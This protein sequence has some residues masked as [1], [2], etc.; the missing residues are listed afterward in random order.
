MLKYNTNKTTFGTG[1]LGITL[2]INYNNIPEIL[3]IFSLL[4]SRKY[5][6]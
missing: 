2:I 4:Y 5:R 6:L 3:C 1:N